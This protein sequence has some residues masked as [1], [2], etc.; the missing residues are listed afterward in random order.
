MAIA[1]PP[2]ASGDRHVIAML[3]RILACVLIVLVIAPFTAPFPTC[4]LMA[5]VGGSHPVRTAPST[6]APVRSRRA[7]SRRLR[8]DDDAPTRAAFEA[9]ATEHDR[10]MPYAPR[11]KARTDDVAVPGTFVASTLVRS[12]LPHVGRASTPSTVASRPTSTTAGAARR[13]TIQTSSLRQFTIL[14]V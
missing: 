12:R 5:L 2:L 8:G 4:D 10:P 11:S 7:S 13:S 3:S 9:V 14:R 6:A 1:G